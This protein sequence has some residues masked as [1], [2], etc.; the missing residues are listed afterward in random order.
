M[1]EGSDGNPELKMTKVSAEVFPDAQNMLWR[2]VEAEPS[3]P[4]SDGIC[5]FVAALK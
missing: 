1:S 2:Q 5:L 4:E 3:H